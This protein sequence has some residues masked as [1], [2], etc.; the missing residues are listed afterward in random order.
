MEPNWKPLAATRRLKRRRDR[1]ALRTTEDKNKQAARRRDGHRCRFPRCGCR[2]V[3]IRLEASHLKHKGAG[4]NPSG[5]R[6]TPAGLILMC[7]QRH[8][9]GVVSVHKGTLRVRPLTRKGCD[10][11]VAW[12]LPIDTTDALLAHR[13]GVTFPKGRGWVEIARESAVQQLEPLQ[14]WQTIILAELAEMKL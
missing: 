13:A 10:G 9:D 5:S 12:L 8:Q 3:S 6:S 2:R 4:G 14:S 7:A 1:S 11:P